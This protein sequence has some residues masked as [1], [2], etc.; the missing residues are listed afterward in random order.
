MPDGPPPEDLKRLVRRLRHPAVAQAG[1]TSTDR[2][3]WALLLTVK[4]G[5]PTPVP[6]IETIRGR[7]PVVYEEE[8]GRMPVARPAYPAE[9]E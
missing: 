1:L 5:T 6:E 2:G 3:E 9:G 7:Y 4:P 8:S